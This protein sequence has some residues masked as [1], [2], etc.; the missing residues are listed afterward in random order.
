MIEFS[1]NK[2]V[3]KSWTVQSFAHGNCRDYK[4]LLVGEGKTICVDKV[5]SHTEFQIADH[6]SSVQDEAVKKLGDL[7]GDLLYG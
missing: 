6:G 1:G 2:S 7:F 4:N 5:P 3:W